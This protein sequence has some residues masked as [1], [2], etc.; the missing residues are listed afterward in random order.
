MDKEVFKKTE[1]VLYD[2]IGIKAE[3]SNLELEIEQLENEYGGL[4]AMTYDEKTGPTNNI[5]DAIANEIIF[6]DKELYRLRKAKK[7]KEILLKKVD[8]A[9]AILDDTEKSII[10]H[11]YLTRGNTWQVVG[12]ILS[13]DSNYCCNKL[14]VTIIN[15]I[16]YIIFP[17]R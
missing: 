13:L 17:K 6:K 14:R 7:S 2:Y 4:G 5:S 8:N 12:D 16:K 9:I 15:K 11:K 3:I 1:R 10:K